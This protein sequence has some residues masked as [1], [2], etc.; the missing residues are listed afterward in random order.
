MFIIFDLRYIIPAYK[1]PP[2][3]TMF[4]LTTALLIL[5]YENILTCQLYC[6]MQLFRMTAKTKIKLTINSAAFKKHPT[7]LF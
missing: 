2:T 6:V 3:F 7:I 4:H 1:V 5:R